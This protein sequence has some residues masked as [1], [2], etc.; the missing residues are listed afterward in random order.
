MQILCRCVFAFVCLFAGAVSL[1][2]ET[3]PLHVLPQAQPGALYSAQLAIPPGLGYP[4]ASC[5]LTGD[6][7]P[8]GLAFD[9]ARLQLKGRVPAGIEKIYDLVLELTDAQGNAKSFDLELPISSKPELVSLA[10][11]F[12]TQTASNA[13]ATVISSPPVVTNTS[14]PEPAVEKPDSETAIH[15]TVEST[16]PQEFN[17]MPAARLQ[18]AVATF[19]SAFKASMRPASDGQGHAGISSTASVTP[20]AGCQQLKSGIFSEEQKAWKDLENVTTGPNCSSTPDP[21][22]SPCK[23]YIQN[24]EKLQNDADDAVKALQTSAKVAASG[25]SCQP[26]YTAREKLWTDLSTELK[27]NGSD[28]GSGKYRIPTTMVPE[29]LP[30]VGTAT[31]VP[32]LHFGIAGITASAASSASTE[33]KLFAELYGDVA[34]VSTRPWFRLWGYGRIGSIEENTLSGLSTVN[35]SLVTTLNGLQAG[36]IVQSGEMMAGMGFKFLPKQW[37]PAKPSLSFIVDGGAI[38]PLT[39]QQSQQAS[40]TYVATSD[41]QTFYSTGQFA[42]NAKYFTSNPCPASSSSSTGTVQNPVSCYIAFYS[43]DRARFFRNYAAGLRL[44]VPLP[45]SSINADESRFPATFDVTVGQN[46]LVT[47]GVMRGWVMHVGGVTPLAYSTGLYIFGGMDVGIIGREDSPGPLL[48]PTTSS[49][50][51]APAPGNIINIAL[52]APNRDR[53]AIGIGWD[54]LSLINNKTQ[55]KTQ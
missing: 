25:D 51:P 14:H 27:N 2:G 19:R 29:F 11:P 44:K 43:Q 52:P 22:D 15:Q 39:T 26:I 49:S 10:E 7:L 21:F 54:I 40:Q 24:L 4:F 20:P 16:P 42:S 12:P 46:E 33:A 8:K 18:R 45:S 41:V 34:P 32:F 9:C 48:V 37:N 50:S 36:Q 1:A 5:K 53:Y 13:A 28:V 30:N 38:T 31:H 23:D 3:Q 17:E 47:G 6:A 35:T 55:P